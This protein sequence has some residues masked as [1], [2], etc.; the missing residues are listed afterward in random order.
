MRSVMVAL[1]IFALTACAA[2]RYRWNLAHAQVTGRTPLARVDL[3]SIIQIVTAATE[4]PIL[5]VDHG[6]KHDGRE[7][8]SVTTGTSTG[9]GEDFELEK[10]AGDW[11][12]VS[13]SQ[14]I[15]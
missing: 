11:R 3:E 13:R 5:S 14:L 15:E 6:E 7:H 4:N 1:A 10:F 9:Y 2:D 8:V 12:I